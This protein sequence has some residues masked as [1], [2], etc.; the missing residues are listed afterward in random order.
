MAYVEEV[1]G[2]VQ[3]DSEQ[4][5]KELVEERYRQKTQQDMSEITGVRSSNI[6]RFEKA[7]SVFSLFHELAHIIYGHI[8]KVDGTTEEDENCADE[9]AKNTLISEKQYQEFIAEGDFSKISM[10]YFAN[11]VGI[12]KE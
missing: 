12:F 3:K 2:R 7:S 6:A 1:Q 4:I 5:I 11:Q 9:Y 10:I 8:S